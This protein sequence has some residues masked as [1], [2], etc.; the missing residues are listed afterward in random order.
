MSVIYQGLIPAL[1]AAWLVYWSISSTDVKKVDRRES[2][3]SRLSYSVPLLFAGLLL[4]APSKAG[5]MLY[6]RFLPVSV[7]PFWIGSA[8]L[9]A[10]LAFSVWARRHLG[11]N[12]SGFVTIKR[13]HELIRSGPYRLV[14]HPIY[15]GL[16]LAFAGSAIA[17]AEWRGVLAVLF[18]LAAFWRKLTIEERWLTG[19]FGAEYEAYRAEVPALVPFLV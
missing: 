9:A 17:R 4:A 11:R 13:D 3:A 10:G 5:G 19:V 18:A 12:W 2:A 1:W 7:A 6:E 8:V 16:L 14:R 15:T